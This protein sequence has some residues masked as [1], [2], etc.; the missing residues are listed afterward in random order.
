[1]MTEHL[2]SAV[3][4]IVATLAAWSWL[5]KNVIQDD[6]DV[7]E[8]HEYVLDS[9]SDADLISKVDCVTE[10]DL[11]AQLTVEQ[12]IQLHEEAELSRMG[13]RRN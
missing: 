6:A 3:A 10:G 7:S 2:S 8:C 11:R 4:G 9:L 13:S 5:G 1:M 12:A